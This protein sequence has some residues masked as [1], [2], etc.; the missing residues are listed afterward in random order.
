[1]KDLRLPLTF[2]ALL[3][4]AACARVA[5]APPVP[6]ASLWPVEDRTA[7][8]PLT[9]DL[10]YPKWI[11]ETREFKEFSSDEHNWDPQNSMPHQ[12]DGQDW[13]PSMWNKKWTPAVTVQ[14]F[15]QARIFDAQYVEKG[16]PVLELGPTFF[17]LS[18]LDRRRALKLLAD[19]A[20]IFRDGAKVVILR[21]WHTKK[22]LGNLVD[23][24]G[25]QGMYLN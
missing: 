14:K 21:D 17:R 2:L 16:V 20:G 5:V 3:A 23:D 13:D 11:L 18:D 1:M 8:R 6:E 9:A 10:L 4:L 12:W 22:T 19:N 7:G 24:K 15:Y 25:L